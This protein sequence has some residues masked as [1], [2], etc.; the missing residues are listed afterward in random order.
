VKVGIVHGECFSGHIPTS[1][2]PERPERNS[3]LLAGLKRCG[4]LNKL[5]AVELRIATEQEILRVHSKEHFDQIK[6]TASIDYTTI[7]ADTYANS[8]SF[9]LA[10]RASGGIL[11]AVDLLLDGKLDSAFAAVRPPGH[12]A[13]K[14]QAMGFCLFNHAAIAAANALEKGAER[15]AI[16]DWDVHHGN[17]TENIFFNDSS[18]LY[19]S[20]HQYPHFPG[21]GDPRSSGAGSGEGFNLNFPLPAGLPEEEVIALYQTIVAPTLKQFDPQLII[22]SAGY[23]GHKQDPLGDLNITTNGFAL[24]TAIIEKV[25]VKSLYVLEGGYDLTALCG[26]VE[27]TIT[28][29][30]NP[31]KIGKHQPT[32]F[33]KHLLKTFD[34]PVANK[35]NWPVGN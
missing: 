21:T 23:D 26:S 24:L 9:E 33:T 29:I 10:C 35:W 11:N 4:L 27:A 5:T 6:Q 19:I 32:H 1:T 22:V 28:A 31:P 12:H 15:V 34:S 7:D 2:H 17:G 20:S 16:V 8:Q 13:T 18:V 14:N 3:D 30:L 25:G